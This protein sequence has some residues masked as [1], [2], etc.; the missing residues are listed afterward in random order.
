MEHEQRLYLFFA[1]MV[2]IAAV[3]IYFIRRNQKVRKTE[4]A[5]LKQVYD[6]A[7]RSG[8]KAKALELGRKYY[9]VKRGGVLSIYDEQALTNDLAAMS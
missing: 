4:I 9:S 8:D 1:V 3:V 7:L 6:A 5:T 2:L